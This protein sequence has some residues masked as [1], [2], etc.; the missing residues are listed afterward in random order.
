MN[1]SVARRLDAAEKSVRPIG[2]AV[3]NIAI[4]FTDPRTRRMSRPYTVAELA[5]RNGAALEW[6]SDYAEHV[7]AA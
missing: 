4:R 2:G 7:E 3:A 5:T 6:S 1:R